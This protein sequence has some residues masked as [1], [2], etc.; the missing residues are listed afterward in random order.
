VAGDRPAV[1]AAPAADEAGRVAYFDG[2]RETFAAAERTAGSVERRYAIGPLVLR[3]RFAGPALVPAIT[4][5]LAHLPPGDP[6]REQVTVCLLDCAGAAVQRPAPAWGLER[7]GA[8]G[9]IA[10]F[11][12]GRIRAVYDVTQRALCMADLARGLGVF[13]IADV[14]AIP[15]YER[16]APL[17][18]ILHWLL[19]AHGHQ[20]VHGAAVGTPAGG[21]LLAGRGGSGKS[22]SALA[23]LGSGLLYAGDDYVLLGS[24]PSPVVHSLYSTAK[25]D[26]AQLERFPRLRPLVDNGAQLATEKALIFLA[27]H[28]PETLS[29]GFPLRALL[30]PRI[31][32]RRDSRLVPASPAAAL[33]ALAPTTLFQLPG[34]GHRAFHTLSALARALPSRWLELGTDLTRI[35]G[36][37]AEVLH[38]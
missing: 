28:L 6:E 27:R 34:D 29:P 15:Y 2:I 11:A 1:W 19:G 38:S 21:V 33:S 10:G 3:L 20:L 8:R 23:C 12:E 13:A 16:G 9:E 22:T 31:T 5:A 25:L 30:L 18:P 24:G 17:R 7:Y 35:P 26:G 37:L 14:H 36:V 4:S 32:G